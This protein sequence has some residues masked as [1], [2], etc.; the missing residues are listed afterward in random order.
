MLDLEQ[1]LG[2]NL[3][4]SFGEAPGKARR[5]AVSLKEPDEYLPQGGREEKDDVT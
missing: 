2:F 1:I 4:C 5:L 3:I